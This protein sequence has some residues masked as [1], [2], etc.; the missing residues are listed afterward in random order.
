MNR[1]Y[2]QLALPAASLSLK[3]CLKNLLRYTIASVFQVTSKNAFSAMNNYNP[4][5]HKQG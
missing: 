3:C 1:Y 4:Q 5:A 2:I